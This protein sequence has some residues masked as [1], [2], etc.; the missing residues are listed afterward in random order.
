MLLTSFAKFDITDGPDARVVSNEEW[1][2]SRDSPCWMCR[3]D[4][5]PV[6]AYRSRAVAID[7]DVT[8]IVMDGVHETRPVVA[9]ERGDRQIVIRGTIAI[10]ID[11]QCESW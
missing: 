6:V 4:F 5:R 2:G 9:V 7:V 3:N 1:V 8:C 10:G 11:R